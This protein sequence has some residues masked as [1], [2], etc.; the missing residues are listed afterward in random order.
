M[1][2][3]VCT[4][5]HRAAER[6]S[7]RWPLPS[8]RVHFLRDMSNASPDVR[9]VHR[10]VERLSQSRDPRDGSAK[11]ERPFGIPGRQKQYQNQIWLG[12]SR[13]PCCL[14]VQAACPISC[15]HPMT[16]HG[17]NSSPEGSRGSFGRSCLAFRD[18]QA[19]IKGHTRLKLS[20]RP[21][22]CLDQDARLFDML[23]RSRDACCVNVRD[24]SLYLMHA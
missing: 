18:T 16:A 13:Q 23:R 11:A 14:R 8:E 4:N 2:S 24:L 22:P 6:R 1:S 7:D 15:M 5:G 9:F 3:V 19:E 10:D 17:Q 20:P 12:C 21:V